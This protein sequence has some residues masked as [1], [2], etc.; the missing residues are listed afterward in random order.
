MTLPSGFETLEPFIALWTRDSA[1][2]RDGLRTT[3]ST[4]A[5]QSYYDAMN[6][7]IGHAL[8]RLDAKSL[9]KHNAAE[10]TL[11]LLALTY[12]HIATAVE[13]QGPDEAKHAIGRLRLPI[14]RATA[15][16]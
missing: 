12:A 13:V 15:D 7:L 3:R 14:S 6:P 4:E 5:R 11:M 8:D 16:I 9:S 1:A 2:E 10:K